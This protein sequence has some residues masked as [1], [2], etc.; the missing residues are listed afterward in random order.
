MESRRTV[1]GNALVVVG[2]RSSNS[3]ASEGGDKGKGGR[4]LHGEDGVGCL[5]D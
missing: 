2:S 1:V 5:L 4:E 3:G